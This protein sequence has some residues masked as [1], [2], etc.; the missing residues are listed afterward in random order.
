M[1][2]LFIVFVVLCLGVASSVFSVASDFAQDYLAASAV[3][4]G[5][6][7]NLPLVQLAQIYGVHPSAITSAQNAHPPL[8]IFCAVPFTYFPWDT[9]RLLWTLQLAIITGILLTIK[10]VRRMDFVLL[11][12]AWVLGLCIGNIDMVVI[13]LCLLAISSYPSRGMAVI[14]GLAAALKVYPLLLIA[15]LLAVRHYRLFFTALTSGAFLTLVATFYFGF[16]NFIGWISYLPY[17][18]N[19]YALSAFNLS[20]TKLTAILKTGHIPVIILGIVMIYLQKKQTKIEALLAG[21]LLVSP[22]SWL[23]QMLVLSNRFR[24]GELMGCSV[25]SLLIYSFGLSNLPQKELVCSLA[26]ALLTC[27][28]IFIYIRLLCT[29]R[30]MITDSI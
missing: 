4:D 24:T 7:P 8:V 3:R 16:N 17:N 10:P 12:P 13:C 5:I 6:D 28:I 14:L 29:N 2:Y 30:K 25:C 23:H 20:L 22:L 9:A 18:I 1:T 11:S 15:G 26:S 19:F 27:I 21:M